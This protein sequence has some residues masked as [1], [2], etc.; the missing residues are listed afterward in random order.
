MRYIGEIAR[1]YIQLSNS[2]LTVDEVISKI[3]KAMED[4]ELTKTEIKQALLYRNLI[5]ES[6]L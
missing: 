6:D 4:R 3:Q 2:G 5:C 1:L